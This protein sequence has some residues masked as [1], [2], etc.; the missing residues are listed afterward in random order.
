MTCGGI[1]AVWFHRSKNIFRKKNIG[2]CSL[3]PKTFVQLALHCQLV[4]AYFLYL[5]GLTNVCRF[6]AN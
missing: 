3:F 4:I 2:H 5:L 6:Q 1:G